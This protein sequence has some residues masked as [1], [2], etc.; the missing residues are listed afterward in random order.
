MHKPEKLPA[1]ASCLTRASRSLTETLDHLAE[2]KNLLPP[3][4]A[5][6]AVQLRAALKVEATRL[7][8]LRKVLGP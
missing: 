7:G 1:G 6:A 8:N 4:L 2:A 3:H 5:P